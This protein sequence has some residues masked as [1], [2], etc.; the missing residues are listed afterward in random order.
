MKSFKVSI[1]PKGVYIDSV[2]SEVLNALT[3]DCKYCNDYV[4]IEVTELPQIPEVP[5]VETGIMNIPAN[6]VLTFDGR[7]FNSGDKVNLKVYPVLK[8][9]CLMIEKTF[10]FS[11]IKIGSLVEINF[12]GYTGF[13]LLT[14]TTDKTIILKNGDE[15]EFAK[16]EIKSIRIVELAR[17]EK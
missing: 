12:S 1:N 16:N 15:D 10:D 14:K 17:D 13:G 8:S 6:C 3:G 9:M 4:D 11:V 2:A 5:V 7:T